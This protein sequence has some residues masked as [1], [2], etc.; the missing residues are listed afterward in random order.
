MPV[1]GPFSG[2][3][4][5]VFLSSVDVEVTGFSF[6]VDDPGFD[7]T[8]T[9]GEG[10]TDEADALR[11]VSG[12][13]DAFFRIDKNVFSMGQLY[14]RPSVYPDLLLNCGGGKFASGQAR[15][16]KTSVK[17]STKEGITLTCSFKSKS[18]WTLP[19]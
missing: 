1:N 15:I 12:S 10:W 18:A 4:G 19:V 8:T 16:G 3:D 9:A 14:Q 13:F 7:T 5:T 11:T 6:D 2:V 17:S